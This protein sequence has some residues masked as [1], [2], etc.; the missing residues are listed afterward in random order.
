MGRRRW[1]R[2]SFLIGAAVLRPDDGQTLNDLGVAW[3]DAG[4]TD[5]AEAA[6]RQALEVAPRSPMIWFNLGNAHRE[7]NRLEEAVHCYRQALEMTPTDHK[8]LVNLSVALRDL[9]RFDESLEC[10]SAC[11]QHLPNCRPRDLI[12]HLSWLDSRRAGPRM[13]RVRVAVAVGSPVC[14]REPPSAG[15]AD[16]SPADHSASGRNRG[17]ATRFCLPPASARSQ[18]TCDRASSSAIRDWSRSSHDRSRRS[19][20][21]RMSR[22][23]EKSK[24]NS[25]LRDD[26]EQTNPSELVEFIGSLP[27]HMRCRLEDFPQTPGYL[28]S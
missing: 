15:M 28:D 21:S 7:E 1:L 9:R 16:R 25:S 20:L 24:P 6:Y 4:R 5:F 23:A 17:S 12:A 11:L 22:K 8:I 3:K 27:R 2:R 13:G 18:R 14:L 26:R 10:L 19:I